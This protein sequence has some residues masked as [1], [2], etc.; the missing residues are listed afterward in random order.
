M[1]DLQNYLIDQGATGLS[2]W[3]LQ[4]ANDVSSNGTHVVGS[5]INPLGFTEAWLAILPPLSPTC[6]ADL[7]SDGVVDLADLSVCLG[8]F[9]CAQP[10][11]PVCPGDIDGDGDTDLA[12]LT[13]LL[14]NFGV[15]C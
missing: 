9:G 15:A 8:D 12:D 11:D 4:R 3:T 10:G 13:L 1:I 14:A 6:P 5:G 2:G 7:N